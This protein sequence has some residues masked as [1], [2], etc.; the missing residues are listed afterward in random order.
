[1]RGMEEYGPGTGTVGDGSRGDE[2]ERDGNEVKMNRGED[3]NEW[4]R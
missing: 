3:T 1:M 2:V 4:R